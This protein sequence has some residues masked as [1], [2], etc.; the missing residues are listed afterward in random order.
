MPPLDSS[1][2]FVRNSYTYFMRTKTSL[3]H[4]FVSS[5]FKTEKV[6]RERERGRRIGEHFIYPLFC[7]G[8][9]SVPGSACR[10]TLLWPMIALHVDL[11]H[12]VFVATC[13]FRS[14]KPPPR[15]KTF[16]FFGCQKNGPFLFVDW[17]KTWAIMD[18]LKKSD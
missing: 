13:Q 8:W 15:H 14:N 7:G 6:E 1:A 17:V 4:C 3:L 10:S 9:G 11:R 2:F 18:L 16:F 12:S 5:T